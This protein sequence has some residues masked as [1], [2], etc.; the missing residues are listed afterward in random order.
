MFQV[1]SVK[2]GFNFLGKINNKVNKDNR[3]I[4]ENYISIQEGWKDILAAGSIGLAATLGPQHNIQAQPTPS[5]Q[6]TDYNNMFDYISQSEGKGKAGRP[7]YRYKDHKG[8]PTI[9]IGHLITRDTPRI[10]R[11]LFGNIDINKY[12]SGQVPLTEPMMQK[13]FR[14][15][16]QSKINV[17][18]TKIPK[19][20]QYPQNVKNAIID[21]LYRGDLGPKTIRYINAGRWDDAAKE[22]LNHDEYREAAQ[23]RNASGIP[24]RMERNRDQFLTLTKQGTKDADEKAIIV[25]QGDTLSSIASQN[26]TTI[27]RLLQVN[28]QIKD[29][30]KIQLGQHIKLP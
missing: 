30:N 4:F 21:A 27:Q 6:V 19:F 26:K 8:Y 25:K 12:T 2:I 18:K 10:F 13:L 14:H 17:A 29:P 28:P 11:K 5:E 16:V 23:N 1:V 20:D 22:Y 3:L 7:G 24:G 9:G 15:D